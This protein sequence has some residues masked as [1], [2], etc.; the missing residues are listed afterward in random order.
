MLQLQGSPLRR[1]PNERMLNSAR[2][3]L[4]VPSFV[5]IIPSF[6][7][8][9]RDTKEPCCSSRLTTNRGKSTTTR[10]N[11]LSHDPLQ[12]VLLDPTPCPARLGEA[13]KESTDDNVSTSVG[14]L[15][16]E[17]RHIAVVIRKF[18]PLG[19]MVA[20]SA[21]IM[22]LEKGR[23]RSFVCFFSSRAQLQ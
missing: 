19:N 9:A 4:L 15:A 22:E 11:Q 20:C 7:H 8:S 2:L 10:I 5:T 23:R 3:Y 12:S 14:A 1:P 6:H 16:L 13:K 17:D 18:H 21:C